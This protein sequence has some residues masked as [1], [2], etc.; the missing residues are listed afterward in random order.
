[1]RREK[2]RQHTLLIDAGDTIQ[3]TQLAYDYAEVDPI[4]DPDGPVHPMARA[5]NAIGCD[6]AAPGNHDFN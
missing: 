3:G 2:G 1:M 6:A 4:T 5:M